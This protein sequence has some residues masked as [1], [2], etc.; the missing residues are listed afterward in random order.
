MAA[1]DLRLADRADDADLR[2]FV[3]STD[4][5]GR[6]R[7]SFP[8]EPSYFDALEVEG[9][10]AEVVIAREKESGALV[11]MGTGAAKPA[12]LNGEPRTIGYLSSLRVAPAYRNG[13]LLVRIYRMAKERQEAHRV[14]LFLTTIAEDNTR[15]V[16]V[17]TSGKCG[18]PAY[19]DRGRF[20]TMAVSLKRR[21]PFAG[22]RDLHVRRGTPDDVA[23]VAAFL[24]REGARRQFFPAYDERDLTSP[25]G[26]LRGLPIEDVFLAFEGGALRGTAAAWDQRPFRQSRITGYGGVLGRTRP[27]YN[28]YAR[29]RGLPELPKPGATLD[30]FLVAL[31]AI[32]GDSASV[33][34]ALLAEIFD[35]MRPSGFSFLS[36]GLHE[37]DPLSEAVRGVRRFEFATRVYVAH[38]ESARKELESLDDRVPYLELGAL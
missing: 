36:I 22:S 32:E 7:M 9:R 28:A 37:R 1:I 13:L 29:V 23:L 38:W 10:R 26:L 31:V 16:E 8:R 27:L 33:F 18:L 24:R 21:N 25:T 5:E 34:S 6:I 17:L 4:M 12:F 11:G 14:P 3:G 19:E 20:V 2:R 35:A 30:H 15:A